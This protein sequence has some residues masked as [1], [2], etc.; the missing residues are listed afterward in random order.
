MTPPRKPRKT[1]IFSWQTPEDVRAIL[2]RFPDGDKAEAI[3]NALRATYGEGEQAAK[4]KLKAI[5]SQ[6]EI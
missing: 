2:D 6:V 1:P 5:L 3:N 4:A